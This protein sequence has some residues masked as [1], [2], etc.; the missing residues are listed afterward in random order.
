MDNEENIPQDLAIL[1][2]PRSGMLITTGE[3]FKPF[4]LTNDFGAIMAP[5][6]AYFA[7]LLAR[8]RSAT[9]LRS[10]GMDLLR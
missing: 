7:E 9:T 2:V 4:R 8:G 3:P 1:K 6:A 10:Y 5:A